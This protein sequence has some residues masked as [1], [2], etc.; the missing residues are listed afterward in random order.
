MLRTACAVSLFVAGLCVSAPGAV[1]FVKADAVGANNGTSWL[2]AYTS[3]QSALVVA[4]SGDEIWVARGTYTPATPATPSPRGV[5]FTMESGVR[6]LGGFFG[7]ESQASQRNPRVNVTILSGDIN[8]DDTPNFGNR[9]DNSLNVVRAVD[10]LSTGVLDGFTIRGGAAD[11]GANIQG[12]GLRVTRGAPLISNC[13]FRDN[14]ALSSGAGCLFGESSARVS[15]VAFFGNQASS[16]TAIDIQGSGSVN[17]HHCTIAGNTI[18]GNGP[19]VRVLN[20]TGGT[21]RGCVLWDNTNANGQG[22]AAQVFIGNAG[23]FAI[24]D[25]DVQGG[26]VGLGAGCFSADP[27]FITVLGN[28]G[29]PGSGDEDLRLRPGSPCIDRLGIGGLPLDTLDLDGDGVTGEAV[30][31][32]LRWQERNRNDP[33]TPNAAN[34]TI[35]VGAYEFQGTSCPGDIDGNGVVNTADLTRFLAVFGDSGE[36]L[37]TGDFNADGLVNTADLVMFLS[38]FGV[39]CV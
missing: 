23:T 17:V 1:R 4:K 38:Q 22:Q 29:L 21:M 34:I 31:F 33:A 30:P 35:E 18:T 8:G 37:R 32:D 6:V 5:S 9:A 11:S 15:H 12:G 28:D 10:V 16:S 25:S 3:L 19:A 7:N 27:L 2:N 26:I 14:S 39:P 20:V 24:T 36:P 13:V